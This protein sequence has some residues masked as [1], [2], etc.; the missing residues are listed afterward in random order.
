VLARKNV[1]ILPYGR[2]RSNVLLDP[3]ALLMY[4][5]ALSAFLVSFNKRVFFLLSLHPKRADSEGG[6]HC[7]QNLRFLHSVSMI[8]WWTGRRLEH[9]A[10]AIEAMSSDFRETRLVFP[11]ERNIYHVLFIIATIAAAAVVIGVLFHGDELMM[12]MELFRLQCRSSSTLCRILINKGA[13][14]CCYITWFVINNKG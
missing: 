14:L 5:G 3:T 7:T 6:L 12:M 8:W 10:R 11:R 13:M 1:H 2:P 4:K 9:Q